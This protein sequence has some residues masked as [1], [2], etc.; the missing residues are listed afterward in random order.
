MSE[1]LKAFFEAYLE[2]AEQE[3]VDD[4]FATYTGLCANL[5][6]FTWSIEDGDQEYWAN[7]LHCLLEEDFEDTDFPFESQHEYTTSNELHKNPKRIAWV[8]KQLEK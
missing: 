6:M 7:E 5:E 3:V 2:W 8:C 4:G 1:Q